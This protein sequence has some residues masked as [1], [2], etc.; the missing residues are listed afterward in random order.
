MPSHLSIHVGTNDASSSTSREILN[1]ILNLK[2]IAKDI[3]PDCDVWLSTSTMSTNKEKEALTVSH[4]TNHLLQLKINIIDNRNMT[5]KQTSHR[6]LRLNVSG[7]IQ[8]AKNFLA[9]IKFCEGK[10]CSGSADN[11]RCEHPSVFDVISAPSS[12][13]LIIKKAVT[14]ISK[15]AFKILEKITLIVLF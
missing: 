8:L 11:N 2:S 9:K 14:L 3:N 4:L 7:C 6:G 13:T 5:G 15:N 10:G 12:K 1:K